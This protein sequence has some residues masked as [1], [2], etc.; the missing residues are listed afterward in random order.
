MSRLQEEAAKEQADECLGVEAT[1]LFSRVA[2]AV[3][4]ASLRTPY[5]SS[6]DLGIEIDIQN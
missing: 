6:S 1:N 3:A 4:L 2:R 5:M